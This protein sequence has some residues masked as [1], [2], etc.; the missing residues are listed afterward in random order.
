MKGPWFGAMGLAV[1]LL[2]DGCAS[3]RVENFCSPVGVEPRVAAKVV[4]RLDRMAKTFGTPHYARIPLADGR[5]FD[6]RPVGGAGELDRL[7]DEQLAAKGWSRSYTYPMQAMQD[8]TSLIKMEFSRNVVDIGDNPGASVVCSVDSLRHGVGYGW[9]A[10][11]CL[12]LFTLN[13]FGYPVV[14]HTSEVWLTTEV[15]DAN[16]AS[17]ATFSSRGKATA[18]GAMYWGYDPTGG[19]LRSYDFPLARASL[20]KALGKAME[21]AKDGIGKDAAAINARLAYAA[22]HPVKAPDSDGDGVPDSLDE[23]PNT[24][25]GAEVDAVGRARDDDGDGVPNG[26]DRHPNTRAGT[27]VDQWGVPIDTDHDGVADTWD[28]CPNT[29]SNL[30]VDAKGCP[31]VLTYYETQLVDEGKFQEPIHFATGQATVVPASF[32]LL[33]SIGAGLSN[34][35]ELRFQVRGHCDDRGDDEFNQ[36]LS[37][38]RAQAVVDYLVERFPGVSREQLTAIGFG[39]TQPI[40]IGTDESSRAKNRRV[41]FVVLNP[42]A[43][44]RQILRKRYIERGEAIPDSLQKGEPPAR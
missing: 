31:I 35:P 37:Q 10:T 2:A 32:A 4:V 20:L 24:P 28:Q 14:S 21:P 1:C 7:T 41:E 40:E 9:F 16:G 22:L 39:R 15:I 3:T 13:L 38:E 27:M 8:A 36:R 30:A 29:E 23:E 25:S 19:I 18:H 33:D 26:I 5:D 44:K 34:L 6:P 43:L 42:D 12:T 11:S 17:V